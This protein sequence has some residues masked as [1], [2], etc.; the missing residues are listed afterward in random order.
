MR[1]ETA[2]KNRSG[3]A[4]ERAFQRQ[5]KRKYGNR[6]MFEAALPGTPDAVHLPTRTAIF[7]H[8]CFWH[9]CPQHY[10]APRA[11]A[12]FW[13]LKLK[14]NRQRDE[15]ACTVLRSMDY[16]VLIIWECEFRAKGIKRLVRVLSQTTARTSR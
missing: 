16:S 5:L 4:L 3:N 15:I 6:V 12:K 1:T 2:R 10:R 13:A 11:N 8:G 9:G 7:L 14:A